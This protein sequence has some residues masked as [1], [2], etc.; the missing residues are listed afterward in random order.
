MKISSK[1]SLISTTRPSTRSKDILSSPLPLPLLLPHTEDNSEPKS[2]GVIGETSHSVSGEET[3]SGV[4]VEVNSEDDVASFN[5]LEMISDQ[6][7]ETKKTVP[8]EAS[9]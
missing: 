4:E 9:S 1:I 8:G 5:W 7:S 3:A 2:G 6:F